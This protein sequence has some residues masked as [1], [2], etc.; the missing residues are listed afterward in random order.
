[1]DSWVKAEESI[2]QLL[3]NHIKAESFRLIALPLFTY[4]QVSLDR[5]IPNQKATIGPSHNPMICRSRHR[6]THKLQAALSSLALNY[7]SS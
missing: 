4:C 6:R 1:V 3:S 5:N 7:Q 2:T